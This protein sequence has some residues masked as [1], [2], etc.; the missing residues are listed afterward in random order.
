MLPRLGLALLACG[1]SA[2]AAAPA[3]PPPSSPPPSVAAL[4]PDVTVAAMRAWGDAFFPVDCARPGVVFASDADASRLCGHA[5][6]QIYA[7]YRVPETTIVLE[8]A[9]AGDETEHVAH[10]LMHW[11][12]SCSGVH[13][14]GDPQHADR[15]IWDRV[16]GRAM[17]A[18][19]Q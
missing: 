6:D 9:Y 18:V 4:F 10:E 12:A 15:V 3:S 5:G 13:E 19:T 2:C 17:A 8:R 16:L 14:D 1:L 11:L 7:C